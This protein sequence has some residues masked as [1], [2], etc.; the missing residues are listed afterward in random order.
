MKT[1][2]HLWNITKL[3]CTPLLCACSPVVVHVHFHV[4]V[5]APFCNA[6]RCGYMFVCTYVCGCMAMAM[7]MAKCG[8]IQP[9]GGGGSHMD[10]FRNS[11]WFLLLLLLLLLR[12]CCMLLVQ[13]Q[14]QQQ[15]CVALFCIKCYLRCRVQD[16]IADRL[17]L[18]LL[19]CPGPL[20][21]VGSPVFGR[22]CE[23]AHMC[24]T[25]GSDF[26]AHTPNTPHPTPHTRTHISSCPRH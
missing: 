11:S 22:R 21:I 16:S 1:L 6:C 12:G 10:V 26:Q 18:V 14:Q 7:A 3:R 15:Q 19:Q 20:H 17:P 9:G 5:R 24:R 2:C 25:K 8:Y 4:R 13:Q 23:C